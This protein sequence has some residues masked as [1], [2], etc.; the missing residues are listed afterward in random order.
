MSTLADLLNAGRRDSPALARPKL[1]ARKP[2]PTPSLSHEDLQLARELAAQQAVSIQD[3]ETKQLS[4]R[5]SARRQALEAAKNMVEARIFCKKSGVRVADM[6]KDRD[7]DDYDSRRDRGRS[8]RH[9]DR[10]EPSGHGSSRHRSRSTENHRHGG[11][12]RRDRG[13]SRSRSRP[14]RRGDSR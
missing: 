5:D 12:S 14:R 3:E 7:E 6:R 11:D 13:A 1:D 10:D 4:E 8:D 2:E 9:R